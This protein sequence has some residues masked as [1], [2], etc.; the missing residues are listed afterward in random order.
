MTNRDNPQEREHPAMD[1]PRE[2]RDGR[3]RPPASDAPAPPLDASDVYERIVQTM[4]S[5][6]LLRDFEGKILFMN[7]AGQEFFGFREDE[8][9]GANVVG[10]IV[11]ERSLNGK[12]LSAMIRDIGRNPDDFI[13]N[14]NENMR[15][16]GER[17]WMSW[18]NRLFLDE[19]GRP[20]GILA[21]G[22]DLSNRKRME[23]T[24][25]ASEA[26]YR[27]L[28]ENI[29]NGVAALLDRD[30]KIVLADGR[31][32]EQVGL[33]QKD[34]I[35]KTPAEV[36]PKEMV[37]P[38][39]PLLKVALEGIPVTFQANY[40]GRNFEL[41][42]APIVDSS[43]EISRCMVLGLDVSRQVEV[44][45]AYRESKQMVTDILES[46]TESFVSLDEDLTVT[47]I[48][49]AAEEVLGWNRRQ[50]VGR[51]FDEIIPEARGGILEEKFREVLARR[52]PVAFERFFDRE[53]Y[54][55]WYEIHLYPEPRGVLAFFQVTTQR[56]EAEERLR[57]N[58]ERF[59]QLAENIRQ[60]FWLTSLDSNEFLYVS[61]VFKE[62][63]GRDPETMYQNPSVWLDAVYPE[64]VKEVKRYL[65]ALSRNEEAET[66]YRIV[67]PDKSIRW[68]QNRGF[69]V[70]DSSGQPYRLAGIA[71]DITHRKRVERELRESESRYR[72]L[73]EDSFDGI[74]VQKGSRI[75]FVNQRL[76]EMLGYDEEELL[77][78]EHWQIYHPDFRDLTRKRASA[79]MMGEQVPTRYEVRCLR[80]DG[81][82][83]FA[84][85]SAR[86]ITLDAEP[87]IQVWIH[88]ISER[89][90]AEATQNRLEAE[91]RQSQKMEAIG[92]LAG[93]IAHEFNNIL[94]AILGY[95][96][97]AFFG[98]PED[99]PSR[100]HLE[101]VV[102]S[103]HRAKDIIQQILSFS[104]RNDQDKKPLRIGHVVQEAMN[105]VRATLPSNIEI[106]EKTAFLPGTVLANPT[107]I[108]QIIFNL[109]S[110]AAHAMRD[111]GGMLE[112][113]LSEK[114][115]DGVPP[116]SPM[117]VPPGRYVE[118]EVRDSGEGMGREVL[119]RIFEPFFT[120]K[121]PGEGTGMGLS[122]V[123][124]IVQSHRGSIDV[125]SKPGQGSSFRVL[126]PVLDDQMAG[127]TPCARF[128]TPGGSERILFVDDD[129]D[130][131]DLGRNML[132][133]LG[134]HVTTAASGSEAL[135]IF[136]DRQRKF[137]LIITDQS[138][139][140]I[141][142]LELAEAVCL[143]QRTT[144]VILCSGSAEIPP[145]GDNIR[146]F[147][148][149]P[150]TMTQLALIVRKVLDSQN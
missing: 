142:G 121:S 138:M 1:A 76:M 63:W 31:A 108:H 135:Q 16:N 96:E 68:I 5:I 106:R 24:L 103:S 7:R 73:V 126:L 90:L 44:E 47:Y 54:R 78:L 69:P 14:E 79:R 91:L 139:P 95:T 140:G 28:A 120:T 15:R 131:A 62:V 19:Q 122:V 132:S 150:I 22:R 71:E 4:N 119:E 100:T 127:E 81:N 59:R 42:A 67:R 137:D 8:I 61:P 109:C 37:D 144:P 89:K 116:A 58:E 50:V 86:A 129:K 27:T 43:G 6:V 66:Q 74:F 110:N 128:R 33:T 92:T 9:V 64:D 3:A 56:R 111:R 102:S 12:D 18:A 60:V 117:G 55:N 136:R 53:P 145:C 77:C 11:P 101:R 84:E 30:L 141:T 36:F 134:Y 123:H 105:L 94:A 29:P 83:F 23:E 147:L 133:I 107:Q 99:H 10:T 98:L 20:V 40:A 125:S 65:R 75:V 143:I 34:F 48:N 38:V 80:K 93:G 82:S 25:R 26:R 85:V 17:V 39:L 87:G 149:K 57:A 46:T 113:R 21:V 114:R 118:L 32:V 70:R 52:Q 41:S 72:S 51:K 97:L 88:D 146:E 112:V 124:G 104:R 13:Y 2:T 45:R 148:V 130:I 35:G 49:R 115:L